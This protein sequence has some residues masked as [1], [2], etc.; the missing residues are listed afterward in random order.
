MISF[1]VTNLVRHEPERGWRLIHAV[2]TA[3]GN[4]VAPEK[5]KPLELFTSLKSMFNSC[6]DDLEEIHIRLIRITEHPLLGSIS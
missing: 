6:E 4:G 1:P 2:V 5:R 3:A